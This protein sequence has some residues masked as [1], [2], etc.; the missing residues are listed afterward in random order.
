MP[1]SIYHD[2]YSLF[3]T[4]YFYFTSQ[5]DNSQCGIDLVQCIANQVFTELKPKFLSLEGKYKN[6]ELAVNLLKQQMQVQQ[7]RTCNLPLM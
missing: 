3:Y 6:L 7:N 2:S 1:H 5:S 4:L